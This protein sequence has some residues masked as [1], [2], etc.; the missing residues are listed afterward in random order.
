MPR[1]LVSSTRNR[2]AASARSTVYGWPSSL[3]NEPGG[4][5]VAT[6]PRQKR[7]EQILGRGLAGRPGDA[8]DRG[9]EAPGDRGGESGHRRQAVA[10]DARCGTAT[11]RVTT[12]AT[13]PAS[14]AAAA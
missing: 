10:Y 12:A 13:A 1:A 11:R 6:E 4:A 14:I 5:I 8:D 9:A 3:L 7:S 2:V